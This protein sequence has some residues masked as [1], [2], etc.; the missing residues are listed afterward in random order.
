M[1]QENNGRFYNDDEIGS[2]NSNQLDDEEIVVDDTGYI[3]DRDNCWVNIH[4]IR[5]DP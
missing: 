1:Q 2:G 3:V 5:I 4:I